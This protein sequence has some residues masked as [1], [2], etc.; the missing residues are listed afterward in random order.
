M[1]GTN[2]GGSSVVSGADTASE[3]TEEAEWK[4]KGVLGL[5]LAVAG[6]AGACLDGGVG[7]G[8]GVGVDPRRGMSLTSIG[9]VKGV[10]WEGVEAKISIK[11]SS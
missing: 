4:P 8:V 7:A 11:K 6:G 3:S 9:K 5:V 10:L 2:A 1:S